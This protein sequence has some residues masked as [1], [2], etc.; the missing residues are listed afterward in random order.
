MRRRHFSCKVS[1]F[2]YVFFKLLARDIPKDTPTLTL[3]RVMISQ[4]SVT[5]SG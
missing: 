1:G 2:N 3:D 5:F 4:L